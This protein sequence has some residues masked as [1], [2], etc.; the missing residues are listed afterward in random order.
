MSVSILSGSCFLIF[1]K[2]GRI[3]SATVNG[4]ADEVGLMPNTTESAPFA[5][6]RELSLSLFNSMVAIS[7]RRTKSSPR[8]AT[9][10]L[11]NCSTDFVVVSTLLR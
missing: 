7:R 6:A 4:L 2:S 3:F 8:E 5:V 10:K 9:I 11:P 1:S